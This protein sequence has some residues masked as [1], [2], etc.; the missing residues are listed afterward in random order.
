MISQFNGLLSKAGSKIL[1][2][3]Q[4]NGWQQESIERHG[5]KAE[6]HNYLCIVVKHG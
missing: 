4:T 3:G 5:E 6:P 2:I 1:N